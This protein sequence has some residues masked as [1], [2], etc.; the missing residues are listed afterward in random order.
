MIAFLKNSKL[1]SLRVFFKPFKRYF[2]IGMVFI[3]LTSMTQV[4]LPFLFGKLVDG[5][6]NKSIGFFTNVNIVTLWIFIVFLLNSI[7]KAIKD[8]YFSIFAEKSSTNIMYQLFSRLI[9]KPMKFYDSNL[10]GELFSRITTDVNA[11]RNIFS[12]QIAT[13]I[14]QPIIVIVCFVILFTINIKLTILLIIVFP[15][16]MLLSI[17]M[18]KK[19]HNLSKETYDLY[20]VSNIILEESLQLIRTIKTF[21]T[22]YEE[23]SK[24]SK[25]L[26]N[27]VT[28]SITVS[29]ARIYLEAIASLIILLSLMLILWYSSVLVSHNEI[30]IG[31]L[32]EF[33]INTVFIGNAFSSISS[34]YGI[35]QKTSGAT[36]K[37]INLL[38]DPTENILPFNTDLKITFKKDF[39]FKNISFQYPTRIESRI[40][41]KF[42]LVIHK[43]EKIGVL[44]DSGGGKS[45]LIQLLLRFYTPTVGVIE[46]DG[47]CIDDYPL[48]E[49]RRLFGVVSQE[50]KLFS[51]T[52]RDN[53]LYGLQ[54]A[55]NEQIINACKISC[56]YNFISNLPNGLDSYIGDN[57]V[58]LS[59]GQRQRIAIARAIISNP[60]VLILDEATSALDIDTESIINSNLVSYMN[61][62]TTI[63]LSHKLSI[64]TKMDRIYRVINGNIIEITHDEINNF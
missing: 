48:S 60:Q 13:V 29:V 35:I 11:F 28:K 2:I 45:T 63:V 64:I 51:G 24:Y 56:C 57:G 55:S 6:N 50:I 41:D 9:T 19:I 62:R 53:I 8:Y 46:M 27:I 58:T 33:I 31:K 12:E 36:E 34:A 59:G 32:I 61:N 23:Q 38:E 1:L 54:D 7:F 10:V 25:S 49:Y 15:I 4:T 17:L 16:A 3:I 39:E 14:Y 44:G 26:D 43:G 21:N 18:G 20:A 30:T 37:I 22:E 42:S 47:K 52:I 5:A 40:F